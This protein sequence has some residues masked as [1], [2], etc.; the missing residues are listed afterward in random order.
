VDYI[1]YFHLSAHP[2][3]NNVDARFYFNS[4]QHEE[5]IVR[6]RYA[7]DTMK[8]LAVVVGDIGTGKTTLARRM[9]EELDEAK[10]EAALLVIIHSSVTAEWLLRKIALQLGVTA[11]HPAKVE[12]LGQLYRRLQ[13]LREQGKKAVVLIDE[14]QM[15]QSKEIM[16]E[17]RGLL[18]MENQEGKL[19]TFVFFGLPELDRLLALDEPLLQRVAVKCT[20]NSF[21]ED[22]SLNYIRHRLHV[23][24][25]DPDLVPEP[26]ARLIYQ[27]SGGIPRLINTISDNSL[28]E[29]FLV[30]KDRVDE[31]IVEG[32]A[33]DLGLRKA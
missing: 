16:E 5:A 6:L 25:A 2:F 28:L 32:V 26:A 24:G 11:P 29:A 14:V 3:S 4:D 31:G 9:L 12:L 15:L 22:V 13:E 19:V 33:V 8:G 21:P 7:V 27:Y 18:N 30:K 17:F 20:L 1:E 10:Y 23:A